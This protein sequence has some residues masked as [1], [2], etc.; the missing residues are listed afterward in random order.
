MALPLTSRDRGRI[1][2]SLADVL[3]QISNDPSLSARQRQEVCSALRVVG[4]AIGRP[5][6]EIPAYPRHLRER[7][8]TLTPAMTGV[9]KGR[10]A[11]ILSLV[12]TALARAGVTTIPGRSTEP[13]SSEW[14]DLFRHLNDRR[15]REGLSRFS[16]YCSTLGI[17]PGDV[18]D[19]VA[20]AFL[21]AMEDEALLRD[22][23]RVHRTM[24][25]AWNRA[26]DLIAAWPSSRLTVPQYRRSYSL[27]WDSFP[28]SIC[29]EVQAY[30]DR[31]S[32]KDL[33]AELDFRPLR[34]ASIT[35]YRTLFR[36]Y[37]S[38]LAHRGRDPASLR[39][40]ANVVVVEV[41]KDGLRF[42]IERAGGRPTKQ[43]YNIAR[44]LTAMARHWVKVK[45]EQLEG[46]RAICRRLEPGKSGL[47]IKIATAS[48]N[49]MIRTMFVLS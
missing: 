47:T 29:T 35:T 15:V 4:R 33:L 27:P 19:A 40:L 26:A 20:D 16:H 31:L 25:I 17:A 43:T 7:L 10:W 8:A 6:E 9:S 32:G 48:V 45:G 13:L 22:P 12:R 11:N 2:P 44:M 34:P 14:R 23:R 37:L 21:A 49:L 39:S 18:C 24:C 30:F 41:V 3:T 38:A 1:I 46:L 42:F 36:A 5:L 28:E